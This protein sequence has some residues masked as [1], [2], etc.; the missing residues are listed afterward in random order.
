MKEINLSTADDEDR[1]EL[2]SK[3]GFVD[4]QE[5][6]GG[7]SNYQTDIKEANFFGSK[8]QYIVAGSDC[9]NMFI[10]SRTTSK[11]MGV[12]KADDHI[13][14]IV[15]PH[16]DQF[17]L[18]TSG[19]DDVIRLWQPLLERPDRFESRKSDDA[20]AEMEA[21]KAGV[22]GGVQLRMLRNFM[23]DANP[24]CAQS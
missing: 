6:Y 3:D 17:L 23:R 10:W 24:Q 21:A 9:G 15:Q 18:A 7:S 4:Y 11:V 2:E 5:R 12:W 16:P 20:Y 22:H 19:I 13:L 8:D 14:N 1:V